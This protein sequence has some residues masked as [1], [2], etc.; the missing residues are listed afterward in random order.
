MIQRRRGQLETEADP[1]AT[2]I[3]TPVC[4][5]GARCNTPPALSSCSREGSR[6]APS[7][8][9]S[10]VVVVLHLLRSD[11]WWCGRRWKPGSSACMLALERAGQE[12]QTTCVYATGST[13]RLSSISVECI[14]RRGSADHGMPKFVYSPSHILCNLE[15]K[16]PSSRA[17]LFK[18]RILNDDGQLRIASTCKR[19]ILRCYTTSTVLRICLI[20]SMISL[21]V[22]NETSK[23]HRNSLSVRWRWS[24]NCLS[25]VDGWLFHLASRQSLNSATI[26]AVSGRSARSKCKLARCYAD[27]WMPELL[28]NSANG[29]S[30]VGIQPKLQYYRALI[31]VNGTLT[32]SITRTTIPRDPESRHGRSSKGSRAGV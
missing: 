7:F 2:E 31:D 9:G 15:T 28:G 20:I 18:L 21:T 27:Y 6:S 1:P 29:R 23:R 25:T 17:T 3:S 4:G 13:Q 8:S 19:F 26:A 22:T 12:S 11:S 32:S 30:N 10:R 24:L 16:V 5:G 14:V